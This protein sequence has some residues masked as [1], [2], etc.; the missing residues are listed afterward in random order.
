MGTGKAEILRFRWGIRQQFGYSAKLTEH[1]KKAGSQ[2]HCQMLMV[3]S[4]EI[5]LL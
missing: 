2:E 5:R 3:H 4:S 1:N